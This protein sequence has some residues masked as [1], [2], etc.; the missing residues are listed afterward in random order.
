MSGADD[1]FID[2]DI[3]WLLDGIS[4]RLRNRISI[5]GEASPLENRRLRIEC[6][7]SRRRIWIANRTSQLRR[8]GSG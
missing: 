5:V 3:D 2:I 4:N 7:Q 8:N 6:V 1:D